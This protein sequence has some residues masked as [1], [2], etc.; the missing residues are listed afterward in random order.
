MKMS[1]DVLGFLELLYPKGFNFYGFNQLRMPV[2]TT[3]YVIWMPTN[4]LEQYIV[5]L[6]C[7]IICTVILTEVFVQ[8]GV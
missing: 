1:L 6:D 4:I 7:L 2:K 5:Q 8:N 3:Y